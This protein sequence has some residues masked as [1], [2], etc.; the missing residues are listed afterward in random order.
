MDL[1]NPLILVPLLVGPI[2]IIVGV[3]MTIFPPKNINMLYGYRTQRSMKNQERWDFAQKYSA[4]QI[5]KLGTLLLFTTVIGLL[6]NPSEN[7]GTTIAIGIMIAIIV[8]LF[9]RVEKAIKNRFP[10]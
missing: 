7:L 3:I 10:E 4:N 2:F 1:N 6:F 8:L 5:I 9:I